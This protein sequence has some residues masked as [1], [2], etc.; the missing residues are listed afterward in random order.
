MSFPRHGEI[1]RSGEKAAKQKGEPVDSNSPAHRIDESPVGYSLTG[2]SPPEPVSASPTEDN[3]DGEP[4]KNEQQFS[5][6]GKLSKDKLSHSR[7][8][9]QS[10]SIHKCFNMR[11][12]VALLFLLLFVR[13]GFSQDDPLPSWNEG[14]AKHSILEFIRVTTE[15]SSPQ[16]VLPGERIATFD[17]DGTTWVEQP[18]YSQLAFALDQVKTLLAK[19]PGLTAVE[20]FKTVLSATGPQS[21]SSPCRTCRRLSLPRI[22]E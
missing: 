7:G 10:L 22:R 18:A 16:F 15:A 13:C 6:T 21:Q 3:S 17:Q 12:S 1:Y 8:S 9:P 5:A 2:W 20:P 11:S 4:L 19:D 14:A